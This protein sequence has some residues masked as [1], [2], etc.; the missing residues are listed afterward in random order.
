MASEHRRV[1]IPAGQSVEI[2]AGNPQRTGISVGWVGPAGTWAM[3]SGEDVYLLASA[4]EAS[5]QRFTTILSSRRDF[6]EPTDPRY[7]GP[8]S[9]YCE[10]DSAVQVTEYN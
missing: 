2:A 3:T 4:G 5:E 10:I 7:T 9:A 6:F 8:L 1:V